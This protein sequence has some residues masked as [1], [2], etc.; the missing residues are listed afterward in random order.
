MSRNQRK[1]VGNI[2]TYPLDPDLVL[3]RLMQ[4]VRDPSHRFSTLDGTEPDNLTCASAWLGHI[5]NNAIAREAFIYKDKNTNLWVQAIP[6]KIVSQTE[7]IKW[8][9]MQRTLGAIAIW[10]N[11]NAKPHRR[12]KTYAERELTKI[13]SSELTYVDLLQETGRLRF[14]DIDMAK[15]IPMAQ[16][17]SIDIDIRQLMAQPELN[18]RKKYPK[19]QPGQTQRLAVK[20]VCTPQGVFSS[21][22]AAAK[23][24][25]ISPSKMSTILRA[26]SDG[27]RYL[28]KEEY[29]KLTGRS[30]EDIRL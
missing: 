1:W 17:R 9:D 3:S 11:G 25:G 27:Y 2:K 30:I 20:P 15:L 5:P 6:W 19:L 10:F 28:S 16:P 8:S 29:F 14:G 24:H 23:S 7:V 22:T 4:W 26:E 21:V 18:N 13:N 12:I